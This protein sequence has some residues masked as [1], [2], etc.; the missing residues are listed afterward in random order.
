VRSGPR[1][2]VE[3]GIIA[4]LRERLQADPDVMVAY[5]FGSH[6]RGTTHPL[7]DVDV[8]VLL[9]PGPDLHR[10]HLDLVAR[11]SGPPPSDRLDVVLLNQAP[12]ALAYRVLRDGLVIACRDE[13]ARIR[14]WVAT[15]DRYLDMAP[16]RGLIERGQ[17]RRIAERRFGRS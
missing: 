4:G 2:D 16:M 10:R 13:R 6:G 11:L 17:R 14:H 1:I 5:V 3:E 15:V 12:V 8:A 9:R 7:S